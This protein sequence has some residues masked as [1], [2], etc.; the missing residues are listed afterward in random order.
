MIVSMMEVGG[1]SDLIGLGPGNR[2]DAHNE[3][4]LLDESGDHITLLNMFRQYYYCERASNKQ[5]WCTSNNISYKTM[6]N[7]NQTF[8]D[9]QRRMKKIHLPF[10]EIAKSLPAKYT[11]PT[12]SFTLTS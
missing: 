4:L 7:A 12:H 9:L 2:G 11:S 5:P 10:L 3:L 8:L 1:M 6:Q